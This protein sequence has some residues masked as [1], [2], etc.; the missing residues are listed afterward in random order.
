MIQRLT[1]TYQKGKRNKPGNR[2][3]WSTI[4]GKMVYINGA[5]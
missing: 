4:G 5:I 2:R 1:H 3:K